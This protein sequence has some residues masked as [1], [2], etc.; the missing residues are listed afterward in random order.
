MK[1]YKG[2]R[3]VVPL[4][5]KFGQIHAPAALPPG[6]N[7]GTNY[8]GDRVDLTVILDILEETGIFSISGILK[9]DCSSPSPF[10]APPTISRFLD[11]SPTS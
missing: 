11:K 8:I 3:G 7:K 6:K 2:S 4:I 10:T 9:P 5:L 1:A